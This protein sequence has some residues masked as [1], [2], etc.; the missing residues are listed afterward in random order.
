MIEEMVRA[1]QEAVGVLEEAEGEGVPRAVNR[2]TRLVAQLEGCASFVVPPMRGVTLP[3]DI[4][5]RR[6]EP[7]GGS[8]S[9]TDR[10]SSLEVEPASETTEAMVHADPV[11]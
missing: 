11:D 5:P 2:M 3:I 10:T 4:N 8:D 6:T 1:A 7:V 9:Q